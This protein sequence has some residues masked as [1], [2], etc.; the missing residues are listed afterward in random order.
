MRL[1]P[2]FKYF[3]SKFKAAKMYQPPRHDAII[4]PFAGSAGY[5]LNYPEREVILYD[6][7][8]RVIRIWNYLIRANKDEIMAIPLMEVGQDIA[9]VDTTEDARLLLSCLV[10][11]SPF[12]NELQ[13]WRRG[14]EKEKTFN[15]LWCAAKRRQIAK[16]VKKIKHWSAYHSL[17][18]EVTNINATWFIDPPYV[19]FPGVYTVNK[20]NPID[21]S[22]LGEWC[23]SRDG[24]VI[25]CEQEGAKWLP[26][27]YLGQASATRNKSGKKCREAVWTSEPDKQLPL[28][29]DPSCPA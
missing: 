3:G 15:G 26:F 7:D 27:R 8:E 16:N 14:Q 24:Q 4:E 22:H 17:Y 13:S 2:F 6:A 10:N 11:T 9:T 20:A 18:S 1:S 12:R 29:G 5:S 23:R 25:V 28:F 19:N 21:F